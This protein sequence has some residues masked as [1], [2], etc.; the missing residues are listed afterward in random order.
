MGF[1]FFLFFF[2]YVGSFLFLPSLDLHTRRKVSLY[3]YFSLSLFVPPKVEEADGPLTT[4]IFSLV[5]LF[6]AATA[7][8][9]GNASAVRG[10]ETLTELKNGR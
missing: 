4:L 9:S 2:R 3:N 8:A 7:A 1:L 5:S 10:S 6:S